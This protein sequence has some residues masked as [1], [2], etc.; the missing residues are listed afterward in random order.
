MGPIQI[1]SGGNPTVIPG[2]ARMP[3]Q[4]PIGGVQRMVSFFYEIFSFLRF[5]STLGIQYDATWSS[6]IASTSASGAQQ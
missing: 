2:D 3:F 4:Y 1:S 5:S 6:S